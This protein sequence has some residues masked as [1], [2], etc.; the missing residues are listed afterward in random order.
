MKMKRLLV[1][2]GILLA[3]PSIMAAADF[4]VNSFSCTPSE[5]V[6][7]DVFSCT[8]QIKNNGDAAG[9]VSVATL[10]PDG[11]DWL[12]DSNYPQASGTS[13]SPGQTTEV[14][15]TG[16]RATKSG[17]NGF[18]KIMLDDVTDTYV[19]DENVEVNVINVAVSVSNTKSSAAMEESWD[20]T[21]TVTA[22]GN[23]DVTLTFT[24]DGGGCSIGSQPSSKSIT[25]MSD[26]N[27]QSRTWTVTHGTTSGDCEF[28]IAGSA[29][30]TGGIASKTDS[31]SSSVTCTDCP[32]GGGSSAAGGGGGGSTT[33]ATTYTIDLTSPQT[34]D[35]AKN[36]K[37]RFL[38]EGVWYTV[39]MGD[40]TET[41]ATI[42]VDATG[43]SVT[44]TV[45]D[46]VSLDLDSDG[47]AELEVRLKSINLI[48][49]K[50]KLVLTS[51]VEPETQIPG[52]TGD[53]VGEGDG[54]IGER[55]ED[56]FKEPGNNKFLIG[57][58]IFVV[59]LLITGGYFF[60]KRRR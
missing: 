32:T 30:G 46:E 33:S 19:D 11:N 44:M 50:A 23:I 35:L 20:T 18:S 26:G 15:F 49:S 1:L 60:I 3:L 12:E 54:D 37:A 42:T 16:L 43:Q 41:T 34:I 8:A 7:N 27:E 56:I 36:E 28:T 14:T 6:I 55:L 2:L 53:V 40:V 24:V 29:T 51:L 47:T 59:V 10:Y 58:I 48:T 57:A 39:T 22:G 9:S 52:I 17:N 4:A 45:E 21:A 5:V 38:S 31:T 13:V 25:G